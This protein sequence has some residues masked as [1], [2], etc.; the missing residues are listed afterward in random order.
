MKVCKKCGMLF[1]DNCDLKRHMARIRPCD[2][3][4]EENPPVQESGNRNKNEQKSNTN[5]ENTS[6]LPEN[7]SLS[8]LIRSFCVLLL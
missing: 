6:P 3:V 7:T 4:I 2:G 1:R 5:P 8:P